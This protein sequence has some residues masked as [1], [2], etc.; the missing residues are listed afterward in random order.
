M[1]EKQ[2]KLCKNFKFTVIIRK[3]I[4]AEQTLSDVQHFKFFTDVREITPISELCLK[5]S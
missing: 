5:D 2:I 4:L 1:F 3:R